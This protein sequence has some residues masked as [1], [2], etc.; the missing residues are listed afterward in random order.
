MT[1]ADWYPAAT[2]ILLPSHGGPLAECRG[3]IEHVQQGNGT[4]RHEF[5]DPAG[6]KSA[7]LWFAKNGAVEQ[8]VPLSLRSWAQIAGNAAWH[9][10]ETEGYDTEPLTDAQVRSLAAFYRWAAGEWGYPYDLAESPSGRG[11]GWHGMGGDAWG[12]PRCPGNL[13]KSQR[14]AIIA[15]AE[16]PHP[17]PPEDDVT[18]QDKKDIVDKLLA[19][20]GAQVFSARPLIRQGSPGAVVGATYN[21]VGEAQRALAEAAAQAEVDK[22]DLVAVLGT[23]Q[24]TVERDASD[25]VAR[26]TYLADALAALGAQVGVTLDPPPWVDTEPSTPTV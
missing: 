20:L 11:F 14:A 22:R 4:L 1:R 5:A 24:S 2:P 6:Q 19:A 12:H 8:Y 18:E 10:A 3:L 17:A 7:H 13:R 15:L 23:V 9:S 16:D 25:A 21:K 26:D